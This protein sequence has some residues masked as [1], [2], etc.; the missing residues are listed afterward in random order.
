MPLQKLLSVA[1]P[2]TAG[3]AVA[4]FVAELARNDAS[5]TDGESFPDAWFREARR[6]PEHLWAGEPVFDWG[7]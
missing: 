4:I 2:F 5:T 1:L 3:C 6:R 7:D